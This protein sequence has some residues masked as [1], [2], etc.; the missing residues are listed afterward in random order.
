MIHTS[1]LTLLTTKKAEKQFK[2]TDIDDMAFEA[3]KM[4]IIGHQCL[5]DI[6]HKSLGDIHIFVSTNVSDYV[7]GAVLLYS[8]TLESA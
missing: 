3:I 4:L 7:I 6:D 5:M 1:K 2:W 8:P